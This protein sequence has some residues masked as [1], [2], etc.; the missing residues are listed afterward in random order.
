MGEEVHELH[1]DTLSGKITDVK[2]QDGDYGKDWVFNINDGQTTYCLQIPQKV[3][4][5]IGVLARLQAIDYGKEVTIKVYYIEDKT[6]LVVYQ[7]GK[8]L[9]SAFTKENPNGLPPLEKKMV[10]GKEVWDATK[11]NEYFENMVSMQIQRMIKE[12]NEPE[13]I[14][15]QQQP[16]DYVGEEDHEDLPF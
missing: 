16:S 6:H 15:N 13:G 10:D 14:S 3:A 1:Y 2:V 5:A 4:S 11:R 8:K 9:Q 12:A 7:S